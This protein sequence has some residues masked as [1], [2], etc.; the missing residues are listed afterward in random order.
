M[1]EIRETGNSPGLEFT[2][3][4]IF[5]L[6]KI[7]MTNFSSEYG[8]LQLF[9]TYQCFLLSCIRSL[10]ACWRKPALPNGLVW[11][12]PRIP[13]TG[14]LG[15]INN[16]GSWANQQQGFLGT[17]ATGVPGHINNRGSWAHQ[18]QGLL[19]TS[20]TQGFLGMWS[21]HATTEALPC[22]NL[23]EFIKIQLCHQ[24]EKVLSGE[25][26]TTSCL[27]VQH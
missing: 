23:I 16:R 14:V 21:A 8:I 11:N 13:A 12:I 10:L 15:H 4:N 17:S 3:T 20:A 1:A 2:W 25:N 22:W 19:G 18:Q 9:C 24:Y 7:R 5:S 27:E 6:T 26:L